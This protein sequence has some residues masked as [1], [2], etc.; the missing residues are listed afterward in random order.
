[1]PAS[2]RQP[3]ETPRVDGEVLHDLG[4]ADQIPVPLFLNQLQLHG[5]L[6]R[7]GGRG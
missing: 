1:M 4:D 7:G 6:R 2:T 5:H 3:A